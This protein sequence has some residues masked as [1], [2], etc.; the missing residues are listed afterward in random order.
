M[1]ARLQCSR[2][3]DKKSNLEAGR[4]RGA[5]WRRAGGGQGTR[6]D[7]CDAQGAGTKTTFVGEQGK[8]QAHAAKAQGAGARRGACVREGHEQCKRAS[9]ARDRRAGRGGAFMSK[10]AIH[11]QGIFMTGPKR[12]GAAEATREAHAP[13]DSGAAAPCCSVPAG[14]EG[15]R[16]S[17]KGQRTNQ[18]RIFADGAV[19]GTEATGEA[20]APGDSA[21]AAPCCSVP[22]GSQRRSAKGPF[23]PW[24]TYMLRKRGVGADMQLSEGRA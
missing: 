6:K 12:E 4:T 1:E 15:Q 21:A 7:A 16:I 3:Q 2:F 5:T 14:R 20:R 10:G 11:K 8:A 17:R 23:L 9:S 13:G 18:Q 19:A 24:Q 22:A